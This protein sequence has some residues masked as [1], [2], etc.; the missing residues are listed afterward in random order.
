MIMENKIQ[1]KKNIVGIA[2]NAVKRNKTVISIHF[3]V[4]KQ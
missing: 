4:H 3:S 2:F 1:D